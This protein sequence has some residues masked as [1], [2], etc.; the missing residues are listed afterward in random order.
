VDWS[1]TTS[2]KKMAR[3]F[4]H[5]FLKNPGRIEITEKKIHSL[6]IGQDRLKL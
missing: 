2:R 3:N 4:H 5:K 6:S 1:S